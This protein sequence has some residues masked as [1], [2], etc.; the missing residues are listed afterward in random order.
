V[1][2]P[3]Y[4]WGGGRQDREFQ[5]VKAGLAKDGVIIIK[6]MDATTVN[7]VE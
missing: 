5:A 4:L 2:R 6:S 7:G 3:A 1:G